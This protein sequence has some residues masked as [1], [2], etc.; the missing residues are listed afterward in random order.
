[1]KSVLTTLIISIVFSTYAQQETVFNQFWNNQTHYNPA[2]AGMEHKMQAGALYRAQWVETNGAP[3]DFYAFYN[4]RLK[5]NW[6]IGINLDYGTIGISRTYSASIPVSYRIQLKDKST[7]S[8]GAAAALR[9]HSLDVALVP[10][11]VEHIPSSFM[12]NKRYFNAHA[13]IAFDN[14]WLTGSVSIRSAPIA[15]LDGVFGYQ[16]VAHLYGMLR[17]KL[18]IARPSNTKL[19]LEANYGTDLVLP[20]LQTN[21]R[22][23]FNDKLSIFGGIDWA[24]GVLLGGGYDLYKKF[25]LNYS[26]TFVRNKLSSSTNFTHEIA[27]VYILGLDE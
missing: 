13:G 25:R 3:D 11:D 7:L 19:F 5:K 21:A 27:F 4:M 17:F 23:L 26:I 18:N 15:Q 6:G 9:V 16:P 14:S 24:N 8:L 12:G 20:T 1:M 2:F 10:P 22:I